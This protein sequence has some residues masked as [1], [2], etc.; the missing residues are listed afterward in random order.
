[1]LP[2]VLL[3]PLLSPPF[4]QSRAI[5]KLP[6]KKERSVTEAAE[7]ALEAE[8]KE[9]RAKEAR[10]K[11]TVERLRRQIVELQVSLQGG[12]GGREAGVVV[13]ALRE[14]GGLQASPH[15]LREGELGH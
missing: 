2:D 3:S 11:L 4:P 9:G 10:H 14:G 7:A 1:M 12:R 13:V 6:S 15:P 8:R 5:L